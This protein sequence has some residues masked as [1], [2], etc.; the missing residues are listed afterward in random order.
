M[1]WSMHGKHLVEQVGTDLKSSVHVEG[2]GFCE[3]RHIVAGG[4]QEDTIS[5]PE[6]EVLPIQGFG[7]VSIE[8]QVVN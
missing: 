4:K 5:G 8:A 2:G 3:N 1:L 7:P 6:H